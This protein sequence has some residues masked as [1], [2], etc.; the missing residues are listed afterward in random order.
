MGA[1]KK[2]GSLLKQQSE[3]QKFNN[4]SYH[5]D[6][7][8]DKSQLLEE[9]ENESLENNSEDE[10]VPYPEALASRRAS[11]YNR[12]VEFDDNYVY[13][14]DEQLYYATENAEFYENPDDDVDEIYLMPEKTRYGKGYLRNS[15]EM[16]EN[17]D[18]SMETTSESNIAVSTEE[19]EE[20][21]E[22]GSLPVMCIKCREIEAN[23]SHEEERENDLKTIIS[24]YVRNASANIERSQSLDLL[25]NSSGTL[26]TSSNSEYAFDTVKQISF[27]SASK[28]SLSL[29][30]DIFDDITLA[31]PLNK[32]KSVELCEMEDFTI[33]PE[34]S[35][36]IGETKVIR[37]QDKIEHEL[38]SQ[39]TI[40]DCDELEHDGES[41]N[42][43]QRMNDE[44]SSFAEVLNKEFD[45]LFSLAR[46]DSDTD[47]T[48]TPSAATVLTAIK[49]PSRSSMEKLEALPFEISDE[50]VI[51]GVAEEP[52]KS[53][54]KDLAKSMTTSTIHPP[55]DKSKEDF[56]Q[57]SKRSHS[58][59]AINKKKSNKCTPL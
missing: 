58:L 43:L 15:Q 34:G 31:A 50:A 25:S 55:I 29:N 40:I 24:E 33:T 38:Q 14:D 7:Y 59:G 57:K 4:G 23:E 22:C 19:E 28:L 2:S 39:Y 42:E 30:S 10:D 45:K 1:I 56:D 54:K 36:S 11:S 32:Q 52:T 3:Q 41:G 16:L 26:K 53:S 44:K 51:G 12:Q 5:H 9:E 17:V 27:D 6:Q 35:A 46:T 20:I 47:I 21:C 37:E 49:M 8:F 13:E 48:I 18:E